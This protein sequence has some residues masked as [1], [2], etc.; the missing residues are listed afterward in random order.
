MTDVNTFI[1]NG[2]QQDSDERFFLYQKMLDDRSPVNGHRR[3]KILICNIY[4]NMLINLM[5]IFMGQCLFGSNFEEELLIYWPCLLNK[6]F[7]LS[8][9][10]P[11]VHRTSMIHLSSTSVAWLVLPASIRVNKMYRPK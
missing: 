6:I 2:N 3:L 11:K 1:C 10:Y 7:N 5:D 8:V 4:V 9:N